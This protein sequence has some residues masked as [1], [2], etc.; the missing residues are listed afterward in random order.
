M[1]RISGFGIGVTLG[2]V[3]VASLGYA[4]PILR[5]ISFTISQNGVL[6]DYR[7]VKNGIV[8]CK[9]P[10]IRKSVYGEQNTISCRDDTDEIKQVKVKV[11]TR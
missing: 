9:N 4:A 11:K 7:V 10:E 6:Y 5:G 2:A 1:R 8:I 3:I